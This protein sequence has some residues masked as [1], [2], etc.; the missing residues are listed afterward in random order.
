MERVGGISLHIGPILYL[1]PQNLQSCNGIDL[2][3][4]GGG[5]LPGVKALAIQF[6]RHEKT[7]SD[8][9]RYTQ[10]LFY[11]EYLSFSF[12]GPMKNSKELD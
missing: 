4:M 11:A 8:L 3:D 1:R 5:G 7:V 6:K 10:V 2:L 12:L 9:F